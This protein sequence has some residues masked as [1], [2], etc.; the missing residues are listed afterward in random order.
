MVIWTLV[1]CLYL[2][3]HPPETNSADYCTILKERLQVE[4]EPG[5]QVLLTDLIKRME[6]RYLTAPISAAQG[7]NL[8]TA[9]VA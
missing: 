5:L 8:S 3:N 1:R 7:T 9:L 4:R 2:Y 6:E